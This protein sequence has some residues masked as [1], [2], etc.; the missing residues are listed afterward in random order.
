M[1]GSSS[2]SPVSSFDKQVAKACSDVYLL[3]RP[4]GNIRITAITD[5]QTAA[6]T[7]LNKTDYR[8]GLHRIRTKIS[9]G[10]KGA[11]WQFRINNVSGSNFNINNLE[12]RIRELK[13]TR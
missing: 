11:T 1:T 2:G 5:E 10:L 9:K 6:T 3:A 4:L 7:Y 12:A 13:R 8:T